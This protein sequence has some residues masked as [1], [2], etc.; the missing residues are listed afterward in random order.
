MDDLID[1]DSASFDAFLLSQEPVHNPFD[2][3]LQQEQP[4]PMDQSFDHGPNG[5]WDGQMSFDENLLAADGFH[6]LQEETAFE[7]DF[8]HSYPVPPDGPSSQ[9]QQVSPWPQDAIKGQNRL[10]ETPPLDQY[11]T[12]LPSESTR[13]PTQAADKQELA[14]FTVVPNIAIRAPLT[15]IS[16]TV[17]SLELNGTRASSK[18][19]TLTPARACL[20]L[21]RCKM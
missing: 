2:E 7:A 13:E 4:V 15:A 19:I 3:S 1:F 18:A 20:M 17:C 12:W 21:L 14:D 5:I 8:S 16:D 6:H 10:P 11:E 9:Y